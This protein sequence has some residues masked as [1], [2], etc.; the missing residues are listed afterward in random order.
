MWSGGQVSGLL[1]ETKKPGK[2]ERILRKYG[3]M[4]AGLDGRKKKVCLEGKEW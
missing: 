3:I 1:G 2:E 4:E